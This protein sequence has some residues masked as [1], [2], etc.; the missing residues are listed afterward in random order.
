MDRQPDW[1]DSDRIRKNCPRKKKELDGDRNR[2]APASLARVKARGGRHIK[3]HMR[4]TAGF[5]VLKYRHVP[6]E[7]KNL[8]TRSVCRL[9]VGGGTKV[10]KKGDMF[11]IGRATPSARPLPSFSLCNAPAIPSRSNRE[12]ERER[13]RWSEA[14]RTLLPSSYNSF[15]AL[16]IIAC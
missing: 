4:H 16:H 1:T 5:F 3:I 8:H 13:G 9:Q 11:A 15:H 2:N 6:T 7:K 10:R 14:T 12:T